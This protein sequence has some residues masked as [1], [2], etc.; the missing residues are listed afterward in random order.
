MG[1]LKLALQLPFTPKDRHPL[2]PMSNHPK[3]LPFSTPLPKEN[4]SIYQGVSN[5]IHGIQYL[6]HVSH[7]L[8]DLAEQE[9]VNICFPYLDH[10]V[11]R[12]CMRASSEKKMNPYELK[13]LLKRAF[14]HELPDCLLTRNTK[15]NYTSDVYYGMRQQF[16][17]FQENFQQMIL[18]ELDLVDIRRFRE[19]FHR[20]S[21]GV[22]VS[23]PEFHQ[24]L[25][26][27]MW[28]RQ[29]KQIQYGGVEKNAVF[30]S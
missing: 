3:W 6:G 14:Q 10:N 17:W 28:L 9:Q 20:L 13:P 30:N 19:C 2:S 8:K 22:P 27:E 1:S 4:Y 29:M 11:I 26:L 23:L 18:A 16:S 24:T 25:S 7:G 12:V 5:T 21:M 15:G